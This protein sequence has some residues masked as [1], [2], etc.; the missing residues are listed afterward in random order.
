M[1]Y[2]KFIIDIGFFLSNVKF[3]TS[4]CSIIVDILY[5]SQASIY[6]ISSK[7]KIFRKL[8]ITVQFDILLVFIILLQFFTIFYNSFNHSFIIMF[9]Q[10]LQC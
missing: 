1:V 8:Y 7:R 9:W 4:Q 6:N 5:F 10:S 2:C 3:A